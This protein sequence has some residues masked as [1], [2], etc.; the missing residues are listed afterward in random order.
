FES[1]EIKN[2]N[3]VPVFIQPDGM[4][5]NLHVHSASRMFH[6]LVVQFSKIKLIP[7]TETSSFQQLL[8]NIMSEPTLQAVF[9]VSFEAYFIRL[10]HRVNRVFLAGIR[11]YHV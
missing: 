6:S 1:D 3:C 11:I 7:I 2:L 8:Y 10:P 4:Y 9:Q 5:Q